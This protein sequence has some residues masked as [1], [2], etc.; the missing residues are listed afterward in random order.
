MPSLLGRGEPGPVAG[1]DVCLGCQ[2]LAG[3]LGPR[4][5]LA[6]QPRTLLDTREAGLSEAPEASTGSEPCLPA[7]SSPWASSSDARMMQGAEIQGPLPQ[8]L[9]SEGGGAE[10]GQHSLPGP[11]AG[12]TAKPP[13]GLRLTPGIKAGKP[14]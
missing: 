14:S 3:T 4:N 6:P 8:S 12:A 9:N 2:G 1:S 10:G 13:L 7:H 11:G 5:R